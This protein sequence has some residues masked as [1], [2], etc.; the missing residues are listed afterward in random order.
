MT[1]PNK[2]PHC[3]SIEIL[4][5]S[6]RANTVY[7]Y[8]PPSVPIRNLGNNADYNRRAVEKNDAAERGTAYDVVACAKCGAVYAKTVSG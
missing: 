6:E 4:Q 1:L 7:K 2:C 5:L 3:G 8:R